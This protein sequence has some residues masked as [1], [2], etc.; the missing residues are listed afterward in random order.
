MSLAMAS[1]MS[2]Q[3]SRR[4]SVVIVLPTGSSVRANLSHSSTIESTLSVMKVLSLTVWIVR[5]CQLGTS[6]DTDPNEPTRMK[7]KAPIDAILG[8]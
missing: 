1:N 6:S 3:W 8:S 5:S 7:D 2:R 4:A